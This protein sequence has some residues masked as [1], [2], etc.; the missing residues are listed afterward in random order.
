MVG[1]AYCRRYFTTVGTSFSSLAIPQMPR[2]MTWMS[3]ERG[4][5]SVST[6]LPFGDTTT[7]CATESSDCCK[8][9][10]ADPSKKADCCNK[11]EEISAKLPAC[12]KKAAAG[13]A[14][15]CCTKK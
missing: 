14:Q 3:I 7:H 6:T 8:A 9:S 4:I 2:S 12:C 10:K 1:W 5:L 11:A 13:E 15:A